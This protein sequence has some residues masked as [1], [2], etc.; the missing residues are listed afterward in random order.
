MTSAYVPLASNEA[1]TI[2]SNKTV[3]GG[4]F[5]ALQDSRRDVVAVVAATTSPLQLNL[6]LGS[7]KT[8][9]GIALLNL[10][11]TQSLSVEI[12]SATLSNYS[13]AVSRFASTALPS[14][15]PDSENIYIRPTQVSAQYWRVTLSWSG[16]AAVSLG[17]LVATSVETTL[18]RLYGLGN[19]EDTATPATEFTARGGVLVREAIGGPRRI[20]RF[21][22]ADLSRAQQNE[23]Q[24]M[25]FAGACG[26]RP[27]LFVDKIGTAGDTAQLTDVDEQTSRCTAGLL[28]PATGWTEV[29]FRLFDKPQLTLTELSPD[30]RLPNG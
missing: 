30:A 1:G 4:G 26:T 14:T 3:G 6:D 10:Y 5:A 8:I 28:E 24:K 12:F 16:S 22:F 17:E 13:D 27:I 25:W 7:A 9:K 20:K 21:T 23:I 2:T 29:D 19:M 11:A 18:T 15:W